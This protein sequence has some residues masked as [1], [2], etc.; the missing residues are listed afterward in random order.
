MPKLLQIAACDGC[1]H[2]ELDP[3]EW[4]A[5]YDKDVCCH[6]AV[7][8]PETARENEQHLPTPTMT[9]GIPKELLTFPVFPA[10]CPLEEA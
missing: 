5:L 7:I 1:P 10:W 3:Q 4:V 8:G 6:P 2:Y 9:R